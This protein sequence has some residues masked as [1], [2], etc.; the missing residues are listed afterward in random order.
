MSF[1]QRLFQPEYWFRPRQVYHRL[2]RRGPRPADADVIT[3]WGLPMRV[4]PSEDMGMVIWHLGVIDLVV[5]EA[6]WR[7]LDP[8]ETALDVGANIG[9]MTGLL[10]RRTGPTGEVWSF[11]P[12]P[13]VRAELERH[14]AAWRKTDLPLGHV[15]VHGVALSNASGAAALFEPRTFSGNRGTASLELVSTESGGANDAGGRSF[16][17]P[18]QAFDEVFPKDRR[19]GVLKIDVEGHEPQ[20][21]AGA[22]RTLRDRRIRDIVFEEH[23]SLP[24]P[25]SKLLTDAGYT[26]FSL[27][28][29][30]WGPR[31]HSPTEAINRP[32]WLPPNY[33]ATLDPARAIAKF[34]PGGWQ[35]LR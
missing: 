7:L 32:H 19:V 4:H 31:I 26:L 16:T 22:L 11:E 2:T 25:A 30:F 6:C 28:Q 29:A 1:A 17:V 9:Q 15:R 20:V 24:S 34:R 14:V 18:T 27:E 10:A 5:C 3:P 8:G 23:Q 33:L 21:F 12:H 13:E 35:V